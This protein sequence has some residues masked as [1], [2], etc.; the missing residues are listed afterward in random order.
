MVSIAKPD[1]MVMTMACHMSSQMYVMQYAIVGQSH[2]PQ[3]GDRTRS[4][5]RQHSICVNSLMTQQVVQGC[6]MAG[7]AR[8]QVR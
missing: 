4:L 5:P 6:G 2:C 3:F 7:L 8:P 1:V